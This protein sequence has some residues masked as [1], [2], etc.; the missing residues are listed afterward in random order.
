M[1]A[2]V[3]RERFGR[4]VP[5]RPRGAYA[6]W[7]RGLDAAL[8]GLGLVV[9]SPLLAAI[10]LAIRLDSPGPVL[11]R[12]RRS[13]RGSAEFVL[14]KFRS[15]AVGTPDLATHLVAPG[16]LRVTRVGALLRRT[17]LDELPQLWN[18]LRGDM[19]LVGP[20]PAL[21]NQDDL[22]ALRQRADVD[23]LRPGLTG[24]AQINGRDEIP[25]DLK[26]RYDAEYLARMSPAFDAAILARTALTL[27]TMR[28]VR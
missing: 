17:S 2:E 6:A 3:R 5:P 13:G 10:A 23:A 16:S 20:R 21:H 18:V 9:A 28:G 12:Q 24:W 19:A 1:L 26:L 27:F 7:K 25:M 15:M 14:L 8:A 11:F 4:G 22:I